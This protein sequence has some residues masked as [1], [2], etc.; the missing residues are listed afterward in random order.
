MHTPETKSTL[1]AL[2]AA[3]LILILSA[4]SPNPPQHDQQMDT[5]PLYPAPETRVPTQ[6]Y[7]PP[8]SGEPTPAI[9]AGPPTPTPAP[10]VVLEENRVVTGSGEFPRMHF[11][12][13]A[14]DGKT[15]ALYLVEKNTATQVAIF[16]GRMMGEQVASQ[17]S[18]DGKRLAVLFPHDQVLDSFLEVVD[19]ENGNVTHLVEVV[20][21]AL[22]EVKNSD[23]QAITSFV[24]AD[25]QHILY[26]K[27]TL[28]GG[29]NLPNVAED[30]GPLPIQ[31]EIWQT[32][33]DGTQQSLLVTAPVYRLLWISKDGSRYFVTGLIERDWKR[34]D[35]YYLDAKS[36]VLESVWGSEG[37]PG[38][39][40]YA[41]SQATLPDGSLRLFIAYSDEPIGHTTFKETPSFWMI[42][43]ETGS[44]QIMWNGDQH[45]QIEGVYFPEN[46]F[47]SP[48]STN[49]YIYKFDG[50]LWVK[51]FQIGEETKLGEH[52]GW[53]VG[54][55]EEGI[56]VKDEN[57][58][59]IIDLSGIPLGELCF[60]E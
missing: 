37:R 3:L 31:G 27:V 26:S 19:L 15:A 5:V 33:L 46:I 57:L 2:V 13:P 35:F 25:D 45:D 49:K 10:E 18:P 38:Y 40:T 41:L 17:L 30:G 7:P 22:P 51:D 54:W 36:S 29:E 59:Q 14:S 48:T 23:F 43:P 16:R 4:C 42:D 28:P 44:K 24:W 9:T 21:D 32:N 56:L 34:E 8:G 11:V 53:V 50:Q 39:Y 58:L 47:W 55:H 52:R 6:L 12:A 1:M 20:G 60:V